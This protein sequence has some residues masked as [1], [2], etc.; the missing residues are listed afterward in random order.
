MRAVKQAYGALIALLSLCTVGSA[1][2]DTTPVASKRDSR[3]RVEK[4]DEGRV[5][6]IKIAQTQV[7][8]VTVNPKETV[9]LV[10]GPDKPDTPAA[11]LVSSFNGSNAFLRATEISFKDRIVT[12]VTQSTD[13]PTQRHYTLDAT[14]VPF[15]DAQLSLTFLYPNEVSA[16]QAAAWKAAQAA[17]TQ[18]ADEAALQ[19]AQQAEHCTGH[20]NTH[21]ALQGATQSDWDLLPTREV[22]DDNTN[23]YFHFPGNMSIPLIYATDDDGKEIMADYTFN[24]V[25]RVATVHR[26]ARAFHLH[27]GLNKSSLLCVFNRAYDPVGVRSPTDTV[28]PNIK[29]Y[30]K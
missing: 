2:A 25:S 29:Q 11:S 12:I 21:Y 10:A 6:D 30:V 17:K 8:T 15:E 28:S 5:Y 22:C 4:Y 26:T 9:I 27:S 19:A 18:K 14:S 24:S 1:W 7:F 23:T 3:L 16:A 13:S 20:V